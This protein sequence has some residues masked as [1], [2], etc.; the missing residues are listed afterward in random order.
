VTPFD[1]YALLI[2]L[3]AFYPDVSVGELARARQERPEYFANG[4]IGG[5][6]GDWLTLADGRVFDLILQDVA[7]GA[8]LAWYVIGAGGAVD[9]DAIVLTPGPLALLDEA[10]VLPPMLE[11]TFAEFAAPHIAGIL[12]DEAAIEARR[13]ELAINAD[14]AGLN[15]G[16]DGILAPGAW[17]LDAH[18]RAFDDLDPSQVAQSTGGLT[19]GIYDAQNDYPDPERT[20]PPEIDVAIENTENPPIEPT[21]NE[22]P[23]SPWYQQ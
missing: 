16:Y 13:G 17:A 20:A 3:R 10:I 6:A 23:E 11:P 7:T 1:G 4:A 12:G 8:P 5:P 19:G 21:Q 22:G 2:M 14:P 18:V 9:R 15:A